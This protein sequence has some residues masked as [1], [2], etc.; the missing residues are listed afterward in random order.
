M[1]PFVKRIDTVAA[2]WP[3]TTNYLYMTY[4]GSEHDVEFNV[5]AIMVLGEFL[6]YEFLTST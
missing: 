2:E 4:N 5:E 3:A 6:N 1:N